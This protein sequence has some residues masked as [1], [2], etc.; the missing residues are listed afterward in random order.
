MNASE[1]VQ[2]GIVANNSETFWRST[3]QV[4][5]TVRST[6]LTLSGRTFRNVNDWRVEE[7]V[8]SRRSF[9]AAAR[10]VDVPSSRFLRSQSDVVRAAKNVLA[11][12]EYLPD[13]CV[14]AMVASGWHFTV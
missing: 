4:G 9:Q 13:D 7:A 3:A 5:R 14:K 12:K 8:H 6:S 1:V 11:W 10:A 2:P